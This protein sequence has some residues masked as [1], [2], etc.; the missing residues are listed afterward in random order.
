[1]SK[2]GAFIIAGTLLMTACGA[3]ATESH[4]DVYQVLSVKKNYVSEANTNSFG[5]ISNYDHHLYYAI[6]Y[7]DDDG[8]IKSYTD[9]EP[10][11][12]DEH[13]MEIGSNNVFIVS[14]DFDETKTLILTKEYIAEI[15]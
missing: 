10:D 11:E 5:A 14:N 2:I 13:H 9:F 6:T 7:L 12:N 15:K 8:S 4:E 1:M 3:P